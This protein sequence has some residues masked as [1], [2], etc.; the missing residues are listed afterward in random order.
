MQFLPPPP[1][2]IRESKPTYQIENPP[3]KVD[4]EYRLWSKGKNTIVKFISSDGNTHSFKITDTRHEPSSNMGMTISIK[5]KEGNPT[6]FNGNK[7][8]T[9]RD[10]IKTP[11]AGNWPNWVVGGARRRRNRRHKTKRARKIRRTR[12]NNKK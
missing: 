6:V 3:Y 7:Y 11:L 4:T 10:P 2:T 12:R 8:I 5:T 9:S 1:I